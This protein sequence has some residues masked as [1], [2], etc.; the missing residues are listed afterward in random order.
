MTSLRA[1]ANRLTPV[2]VVALLLIAAGSIQVPAQ[3]TTTKA[4]IILTSDIYKMNEQAGRGG[5]PRLG[6][7]VKTERAANANTIVVHAGDALSPCLLCGFD[8]GSHVIDLTNRISPDIFVP[9][10][11]EYDFGRDIYLKRMAAAK[12][13]ILAANLRAPDGNRIAGHADTRIITFGDIKI[14]I[15][16]ATAE[17]SY[18]KSNPEDLKITPVVPTVK[19]QA[20]ALRAAGAD[21]VVAVVHAARDIDFAIYDSR[22]VDILLSGDDHD[23]RMMYDGRTVMAEAGQDAVHVIAID[24][25]IDTKMADGKREVSWRPHFRLLDSANYTPDPEI[26]AAVKDYEAELSRELDVPVATLGTPLDSRNATVR[27]GEAAIGNFIA[28]AAR[29]ST[30]ADIAVINGGGIRGGKLYAAGHKLTRRDVITEL[31]FG[32]L[33]IVFELKGA[34]VRQMAEIGVSKSPVAAGSFM[35]Y[36]GMTV[37]ADLSKPAGA[38]VTA[39]MVGAEPLSDTRIYKVA[40]SDFF[41][42]GGD[43]YVMFKTAKLAT[44]LED[45]RLLANDVMVYARKLEIID[46][47][48]E[49]RVV[50]K[51]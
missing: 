8:Q 49:G 46:M 47:K 30:A 44:R 23:L 10:N 20:T 41:Q 3:T 1:L 28:D 32:N 27:S 13:P 15:V 11:H 9:G 4:T 22:V 5:Y 37:E 21:L 40:G 7:I 33:N 51:Q 36:S 17:D 6:A 19:E 2:I 18:K 48:T 16:G 24:L 26:L 50:L 34:E 14:G 43:G 35:H 45:A 29:S 38:R 12:F 25:T 31:P 42:R 39:I